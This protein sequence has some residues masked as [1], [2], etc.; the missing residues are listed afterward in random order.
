MPTCLSLMSPPTSGIAVHSNDVMN[1]LTESRSDPVLG[2]FPG[3]SSRSLTACLH[4]WVFP[5]LT[6][7]RTTCVRWR[8]PRV[9][10]ELDY[11]I[12]TGTHD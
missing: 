5:Y 11:E 6:T 7:R 1:V 2:K 9:R 12:V 4:L 3:W 10:I 8:N